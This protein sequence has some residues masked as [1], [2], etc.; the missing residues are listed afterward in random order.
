ALVARL[1]GALP[2]A[3]F[4]RMYGQSEAT[5]RITYLPPE[6]LADKPESVGVPVTGVELR[7]S[8]EKGRSL[9]CDRVG[10]VHVRGDSVMLGYWEAPE[11]TAAVLAEGWLR[12]GD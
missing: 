12:T 6:R 2:Q 11:A 4:F 7:I 5:S 1:V 10:E 3:R 8:D 9:P